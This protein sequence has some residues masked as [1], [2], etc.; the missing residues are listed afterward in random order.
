VSRARP[1]RTALLALLSAAVLFGCGGDGAGS[2]LLTAR[3]GDLEVLLRLPGTL[4]PVKER[5]IRSPRWGEIRRMAPNG[6][7]VK[8]GQVVLELDSEDIENSINDRQAD[9]QVRAAELRQVKQEVEKSR[10]RAVLRHAAAKLNR[11]LE[12]SKYKELKAK[13]TPRELTD[14]RSNL[15]L[16]E[17]LVKAAEEAAV[18]VR[19]L[20]SSGYAAQQEQ[21]EADLELSRARADLAAAE[22]NLKN[23]QAGT[24]TSVLQEAAIRVTQARLTERSAEKSIQIVKEWSDAKL[25]RFKRRMDREK[26]RLDEVK[27]SMS[28]YQAKAPNDGV[29]LHAKRRWGGDWQPGRHV[30]Q[31]ATVMSIPD[32]SRMKVL[33][34][35]P[36]DSVRKLDAVGRTPARVNVRALPGKTFR[37]RLSKMG[38]VGRDEFERLDSS[39]SGKLG[40]AERQVFEAEVELLEEDP[41]LK[42]GFGA[43]AE[44]ILRRVENAVIVP[45][46]A[47]VTPGGARAAR[48]PRGGKRPAIPRP[49]RPPG[50]AKVY[51][52][53]ERGFEERTVRIL[54]TNKFEAA[55]EGPVR[56][57]DQLHPGRPAS[58]IAG[59]GKSAA[60]AEEGAK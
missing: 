48:R 47:L 31:G 59:N 42:P 55:L 57:G 2:S 17:A 23:V 51:V 24:D 44:L 35:V 40:R 8:R 19:E 27:R 10:R 32:L 45:L 20:V 53:T 33:V 22:A 3:R 56:E 11:E 41:R 28:Q 15:K 1:A 52:R 7:R 34:Q 49:E 50:S 25:A 12:E 46:M 54:A 18:L 60:Q 21:R 43:D 4:R 36:A 16:S 29:V 13:P 26:E 6:S 37:A 39:T 38:S 58:Y 14:A 30:W 9:V 5:S